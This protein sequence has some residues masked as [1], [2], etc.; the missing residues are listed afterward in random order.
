MYDS[1]FHFGRQRECRIE[2]PENVIL[3]YC[4][5]NLL[6]HNNAVARPFLR[7]VATDHASWQGDG[8]DR[9]PAQ[10]CARIPMQ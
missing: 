9:L 5:P 10:V 3:L 7:E 1:N 4:Q 2:N 6:A 8:S